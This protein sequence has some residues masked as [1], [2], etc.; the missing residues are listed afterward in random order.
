MG[1]K[2]SLHQEGFID[3]G[4]KKGIKEGYVRINKQN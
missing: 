4:I 1:V 3:F 2:I